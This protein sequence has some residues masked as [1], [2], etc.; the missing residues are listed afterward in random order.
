MKLTA[1]S[2]LAILERFIDTS[3]FMLTAVTK[4][5]VYVRVMF[6][7]PFPS[8]RQ[9]KYLFSRYPFYCRSQFCHKKNASCKLRQMQRF[10][11]YCFIY[12]L[13][14][15]HACVCM[16]ICCA[17]RAGVLD[18]GIHYGA[19]DNIGFDGVFVFLLHSRER[20]GSS[21]F[22]TY[23]PRVFA[24]YCQHASLH[25]AAQRVQAN[26]FHFPTFISKMNQYHIEKEG[27]RDEHQFLKTCHLVYP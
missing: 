24:G 20:I 4:Q 10:I 7:A 2:S 16:A 8:S 19:F 18:N 15:S 17:W 5:W 27:T 26:I 12:Q 11:F 21:V 1:W 23:P 22:E 25:T 9:R 6:E 3:N 13:E 14:T